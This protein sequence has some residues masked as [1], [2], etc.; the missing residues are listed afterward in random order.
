MGFTERIVELMQQYYGID[1]LNDAEGITDVTREK[2]RAVLSDA[3]Y[4][5]YSV[6]EII[7]QFP[8]DFGA[9]R[10]RRIARTET[11]TAANGAAIINAK[12]TGLPMQKIWIAVR[13]K[14]TRHNHVMVDNVTIP[15][16]DAFNVGG[17]LME[18]PGARKTPEGLP[19]SGANVINCRCTCGFNVIE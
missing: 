14:R 2:I 15:L 10:A 4:L 12:E 3:S 5:G 7:A 17:E 19:V 11:V 13:D 8:L 9:K 16:D 18:Q 6:D 1:L